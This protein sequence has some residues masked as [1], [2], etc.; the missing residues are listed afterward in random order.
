MKFEIGAS[1]VTL[2]LVGAADAADLHV[3][4]QYPTIQ[5]AV[6]AAV[7]G[8]VIIVQPG[9]YTSTHPGWVV[10]MAGKRVTLRSVDP[11]DPVV[12]GATIIDGQHQRRGISCHSGET[13]E[14]VVRGFTI[15]NG[16]T[17]P[18]DYSGNGVITYDEAFGGNIYVRNC[19]VRV[20]NCSL[21]NGLGY[22]QYI[23]NAAAGYGSGIAMRSSSSILEN[24]RIEGNT[25]GVVQNAVSCSFGAPSLIDC[26]I[27]N[28]QG[29]GVL[30]GQSG[31]RLT[32]TRCEVR[33]NSGNGV[34]VNFAGNAESVFT[35]CDVSGQA[36]YGVTVYGSKVSLV[37]CHVRQNQAGY[38]VSGSAQF[39]AL[40]GTV[41]ESQICGNALF[42]TEG[43]WTD[44]GG[45]LVAT[46]CPSDGDGDGI[47]DN[48]DNCPA[49]PNPAQED[50][51]GDGVGDVC[52][53][54][55]GFVS[56][57]N[58]NGLPDDC[59]CLG[60]VS[61]NGTVDGID[62]AAVLGSWGSAG[63]GE[64]NADIDR[65]GLVNGA[66]LAVVLSGWGPCPN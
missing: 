12:V 51:D 60:D 30:A 58:Q 62:L 57:W 21:L 42:Q 34:T 64:F 4:A 28:N 15:R 31:F 10:S 52:E 46:L 5:A 61:G 49:L 47:W 16:F 24:C 27:V 33:G 11:N 59:E 2:A 50:C 7:T 6:N 29:Y 14:T 13:I 53:I 38:Q 3:P 56:D 55:G 44:G 32:M 25:G 66:D 43:R 8:D 17:V 65:S 20:V 40:S 36:G 63:G 18:Y 48:D 1:V 54:A 45:N 9:V 19:A 23:G 41:V 22:N 39:P 37:R 26:S 35:D